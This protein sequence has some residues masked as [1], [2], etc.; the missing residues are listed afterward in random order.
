M[1]ISNRKYPNRSQ[2]AHDLIHQIDKEML[3]LRR[4]PM[5]KIGKDL[6]NENAL[7][8][9]QNLHKSGAQT[10]VEYLTNMDQ[11]DLFKN[12]LSKSYENFFI[13]GFTLE[14]LDNQMAELSVKEKA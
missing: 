10:S 6:F 8:E 13:D 12:I 2:F 9:S 5:I 14:K 4:K 3:N 11:D 7:P 1:E